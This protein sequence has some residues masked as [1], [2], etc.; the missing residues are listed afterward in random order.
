MDAG[1][2]GLYLF[3]LRQLMP[4]WD[5][6]S[7]RWMYGTITASNVEEILLVHSEMSRRL[8]EYGTR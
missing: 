7:E 4:S 1:I 2:D 6:D 3:V 8:R 5:E